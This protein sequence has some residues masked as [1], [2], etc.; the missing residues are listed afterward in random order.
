MKLTVYSCSLA[1]DSRLLFKNV[2]TVYENLFYYHVRQLNPIHTLVRCFSE[3][4]IMLTTYAWIFQVVPS[5]V[6]K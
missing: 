2:P 5:R 4:Y 6:C 1:A 3:H